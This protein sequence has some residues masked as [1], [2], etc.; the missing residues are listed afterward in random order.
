MK[1]ICVNVGSMATCLLLLILFGCSPAEESR[2]TPAP[3]AGTPAAPQNPTQPM[4]ESGAKPGE[5][6]STPTPRPLPADTSGAGKNDTTPETSPPSGVAAAPSAGQEQPAIL[7]PPAS[8][9]VPQPT[10]EQR[11]KWN[12][13]VF[14]PLQLLAIRDGSQVGFANFVS[15]TADGRRYLLGGSKFTVWAIDGSEPQHVLAEM[16]SGND[17]RLLSFAVAPQGNWCVMGDARGQLRK[18]DWTNGQELI[19]K[20]SQTNAVVRVAISPDGKEIAT[21]PYVSEVTIWDAE[22]LEKKNSFKFDTREIKHL[23]YLAPQVL[24]AAGE[25]L[26]SWDTASGKQLKSYPAGRYQSAIALSA[27]GQEL[28][29]GTDEFLQ[30]WNQETHAA[31]GEYRGVPFRDSAV[32]FSGNG[33]WLAV[34]SGDAVRILDAAT[35]RMLQVIDAAGSGISDIAW[36]GDQPILLVATDSGKT[37]IW[38]RPK[39]AE[40][41]EL[42]PLSG[43]AVQE[44]PSPL[45]PATVA[46][47]LAVLD[48][49]VLPKLPGSKPQS[50]SF[51]SISYAAP[52]DSEEIKM[53]Y[54]H[55][56]SERGWQEDMAQATQYA[57]VFHRQG[58]WLNLSC[59]GDKPG[60]TYASL[61]LLGNFDLRQAPRLAEHLKETTYEGPTT[62]IYK[63]AANLLQI[64][65]GLLK[66]FQEAGWTAVARLGRSHSENADGRD[67]EFVRNGT[68][69]RVMIQKDNVNPDWFSISYASSLS[70]H[71]LPVPPDAGLMEWDDFGECRIVANTTLNLDEAVRFFEEAMPRHGW[72]AGEQGRHVDDKGAYLPFT[73]GQRDV[74]IGLT[75]V[76]NGM[77]RIHAGKYSKDSWQSPKGDSGNEADADAK[78]AVG[79]EAADLPILHAQGEARYD[80]ASGQIRVVLEKISLPE[81]SREYSEAMRGL[82]WEVKPFGDPAEDSVSL[83]FEKDGK[84]I[85]YQSSIDPRGERHLDVSGNGLLWHKPIATRSLISYTAWLKNHH[86]PASLQRLDEYRQQMEPLLQPKN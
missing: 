68:L 29:F 33:E 79:L 32:R 78:S 4:N 85:Y 62:V 31:A 24:L 10:A 48:L 65:T 55:I 22:T 66:K 86:H 44:G 30:R 71:S 21:I 75:P 12:F 39:D 41:W 7:P 3:V 5:T 40:A 76:G 69:L 42:K 17:E 52:A 54:R 20:S 72:T 15:A 45:V 73:W 25:T 11:A 1:T 81:L 19:A 35:G 60:E 46:E 53:F 13:P 2:S 56:L 37:R 82:G 36:A 47:N 38:G 8:P 23:Q 6:S 50:D 84:I 27:N 63:V 14:E 80:S 9:P 59:Y 57:N 28:I 43:S 16:G 34:A 18:F 77:V 58:F 67:F 49:R 74:T 51:S 64:E 26:S 61:V 70:L 83:H